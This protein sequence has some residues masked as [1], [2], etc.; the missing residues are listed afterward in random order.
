M[1]TSENER[2]TFD[3]YSYDGAVVRFIK[4]KNLGILKKYSQDYPMKDISR[5]GMRFEFDRY[6]DPGSFLD[7]IIDIPGESNIHMRGNVQWVME[8]DSSEKYEIGILF[9]PYGYRKKYNPFRN[10]DRLK[11]LFKKRELH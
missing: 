10:K 3:R 8:F 1:H 11:N 9:T 2:R 4:S 5:S 6:S 7:I